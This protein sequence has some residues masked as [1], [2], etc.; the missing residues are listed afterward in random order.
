MNKKIPLYLAGAVIIGG[1]CVDAYFHGA[2]QGQCA[3][4]EISCPEGR[5]TSPDMPHQNPEPVQTEAR[6]AVVTTSTAS[7]TVLT[8]TGTAGSLG[9]TLT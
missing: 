7:A 5:W 2:R 9:I 4:P 8:A 3:N 6:V 1:G